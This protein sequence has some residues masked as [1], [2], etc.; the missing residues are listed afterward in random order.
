MDQSAIYPETICEGVV[1]AF[2]VWLPAS[3]S[4]AP[5][6]GSKPARERPGSNRALGTPSPARI[7]TRSVAGVVFALPIYHT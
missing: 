2:G 1:G 7:A 6:N 5:R 3:G 4:T